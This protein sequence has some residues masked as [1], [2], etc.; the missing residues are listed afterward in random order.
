MGTSGFYLLSKR[1]ISGMIGL[2]SLRITHNERYDKND[3]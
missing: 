1:P 3:S 2:N